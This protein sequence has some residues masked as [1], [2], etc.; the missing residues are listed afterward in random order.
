[1]SPAFMPV[2]ISHN[3]YPWIKVGLGSFRRFFPDSPVLVIE[4]NLDPGMQGYES[5][6]EIERRW[7]RDWCSRDQNSHFEQTG[8]PRTGHG[9]AL[10]FGAQWCRDHGIRWML[11]FEPDCL[12]DGVEWMSK[13]LEA[14]EKGV[15]MAGS[16]RK[17]YGPIH[18]TPSIW[19]VSQITSS[20]K[21]QPRGSDANH[22]RF[23]ELV[24]MKNLMSVIEDW[25]RGY[26]MNFWDTAQKTWFDAA[27]H[28]KTLL[29]E[30]DP[31]FQH[32]WCGSSHNPDPSKTGD[33]RVTQY[34]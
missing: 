28:D 29:V 19:D 22:P 30:G 7:V 2:I 25:E 11:P 13:L 33:F 10:D 23:Y 5:R 34:L 14:T 32:F 9:A 24:D 1:M 17:S 27:I 26:W 18:P 12:I 31:S 8:Y 4:N 3:S 21:E 20:F 16:H 6:F 15:W